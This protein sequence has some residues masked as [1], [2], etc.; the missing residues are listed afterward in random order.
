MNQLQRNKSAWQNQKAGKGM[1]HEAVTTLP[2]SLPSEHSS[3]NNI[4][5]DHD[6]RITSHSPEIVF[7]PSVSVAPM[8]SSSSTN[9]TGTIGV[10]RKELPVTNAQPQAQSQSLN[11]IPATTL[12]H[13]QRKKKKQSK[14]SHGK[15][16]L[17]SFL[18]SL[19]DR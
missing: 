7:S 12:L 14:N 6:D 17:M 18:S 11:T 5:K 3:V 1:K 16:D 2:V 8:D 4:I 10:K 13:Q 19:N 15:N 9:A